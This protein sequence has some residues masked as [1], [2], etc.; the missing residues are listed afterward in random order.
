M[1]GRRRRQNRN[2]LRGCM[3]NITG[4]AIMLMSVITILRAMGERK[5]LHCKHKR[6]QRRDKRGM[7]MTICGSIEHG[8]T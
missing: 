1:H 7:K 5:T 4:H 3:H 8:V 6:K 2:L